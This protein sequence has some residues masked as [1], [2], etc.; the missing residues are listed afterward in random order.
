MSLEERI[1][2]WF[3]QGAAAVGNGEAEAAFFELR[4]ALEAGELRS[5]EPDASLPLGLAG[6]CVGKTGNFA[7]ISAWCSGRDGFG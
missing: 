5:A 3:A 1:E 4:N 7:G 6:E 2:H